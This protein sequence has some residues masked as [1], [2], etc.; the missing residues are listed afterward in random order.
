MLVQPV[1]KNKLIKPS[2][3]SLRDIILFG[4]VIAFKLPD[5]SHISNQKLQ[6]IP[7]ILK[8]LLALL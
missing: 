6:M 8:S 7:I 5:C 2:H 4:H 1:S 3:I